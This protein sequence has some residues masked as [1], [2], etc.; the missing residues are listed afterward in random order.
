ME[1]NQWTIR[2]PHASMDGVTWRDLDLSKLVESVTRECR[3]CVIMSNA[4]GIPVPLSTVFV[5]TVYDVPELD[6]LCRDLHPFV[7]LRHNNDEIIVTFSAWKEYRY[8]EDNRLH[9]ATSPTRMV[10]ITLKRTTSVLF[11]CFVSD[12]VIHPT[13]FVDDQ[14]NIIVLPKLFLFQQLPRRS[15][16]DLLVNMDHVYRVS[17]CE[18]HGSVPATFFD[19]S[20]EKISYID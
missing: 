13:C 8:D 10:T 12:I 6:T 4:H 11:R 15:T 19:P 5:E 2:A 16:T 18:R 3:S 1:Y 20:V 7:D 14:E 17:V 9:L